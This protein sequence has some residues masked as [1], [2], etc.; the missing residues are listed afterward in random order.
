MALGVLAAILAGCASGG[1]SAR[2]EHPP[3]ALLGSSGPIPARLE[4]AASVARRFAR[5]YA[6]GAYRRRA[7]R[8]REESAAA[9]RAVLAAASRVPAARRRLRPRL[10]A[11]RLWLR[12]DGGI[13]ALARI[14]DGRFPPFS[15][16]FTLRRRGR[17]WLITSFAP[18][19]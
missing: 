15:V 1:G 17:G 18:P 19:D 12:E 6:R 14:G 2:P 8:I 7:P 11:L 10:L 16:G 4:G 5:A 3:A 9:F 13:G